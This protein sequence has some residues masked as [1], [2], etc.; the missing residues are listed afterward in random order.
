MLQV[1]LPYVDGWSARRAEHAEL[2]ALLLGDCI[3]P[4]PKPLPGCSEAHHIFAVEVENRDRVRA[5]LCENGIETGVH[6][7]LPVHLQPAYSGLAY[8]KGDL[9]IS[10]RIAS[11]TLS[12]PIFAELTRQQIDRVCHA[13]RASSKLQ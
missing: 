13:M 1:K 7:P 11:R 8:R 10:E 5:L 2:Y 4:R 3:S 9:P 6:Y 12:L